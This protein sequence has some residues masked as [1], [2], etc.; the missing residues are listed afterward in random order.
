MTRDGNGLFD[1]VSYSNRTHT[2]Q[3]KG[4]IQ[5]AGILGGIG[6]A[7]GDAY[8]TVAGVADHAVG[9]T[10]EWFGRT[11]SNLLGGGGGSNSKDSEDSSSN[12]ED[13]YHT[14]G[15]MEYTHDFDRKGTPTTTGDS[16]NGQED[17][18]NQNQGPDTKKLAMIGGAAL[19]GGLALSK[20]GGSSGSGGS[21][22]SSRRSVRTTRRS[23]GNGSNN[24]NN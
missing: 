8:D 7:A 24:G 11:T 13:Q 6:D 2:R 20:M 12:E 5:T 3:G 1:G 16:G 22:R 19:A 10:D 9:S 4:R 14:M 21:G 23:G 15:D 17:S 18:Q